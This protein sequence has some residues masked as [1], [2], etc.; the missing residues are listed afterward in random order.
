MSEYKLWHRYDVR[1]AAPKVAIKIG[2][3]RRDGSSQRRAKGC[4]F[5]IAAQD[6]GHDRR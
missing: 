2:K 6:Q 4:R 3:I 5:T 1:R